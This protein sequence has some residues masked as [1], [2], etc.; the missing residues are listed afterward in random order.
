MRAWGRIFTGRSARSWKADDNLLRRRVLPTW[1]QRAIVDITRLDVRALVEEVAEAG[2]PLVAKRVVALISK[3][4]E[5]QEQGP[6][7]P[8]WATVV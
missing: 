2:G 7:K 3:L 1:R 4:F 6:S 5:R 8:N